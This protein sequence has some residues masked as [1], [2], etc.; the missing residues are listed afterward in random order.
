M[1]SNFE[2]GYFMNKIIITAAVVATTLS[3]CGLYSKYEG[4]TSVDE[5]L[6]GDVAQSVDG[7]TIGDVAWSDLFTDTKLRGYIAQALESN[8][9]LRMAK[10]RVE[11]SEASL[12]SSRLAYLPSV[13][14]APEG[15]ISGLLESGSSSY[16]SYTL[17]IAASWELDL[18]G[19]I[20]NTKLRTKMLAD[21]QQYVEQATR[22]EIVAAVANVYYTIAMLE[23]QLQ[24]AKATEQSWN[25]SYRTSQ[26][27]MDAGMMNQAGLSQIEAGLYSVQI[28]VAKLE[29][30]LTTMHNTMC[31]LLATAPTEIEVG[32]LDETIIPANLMVGVPLQML[33]SRPDVMAAESALAASFYSKNV[34]RSALYP[35]LSLTGALGWSNSF[36]SVV[37]DP[38][39]FIY[40]VVGQ[41]VQ[42]IFNRGLTRAQIKVATADLEIARITFEQKLLDAGIEVNNS[43]RA[44]Q[45][46]SSNAKLYSEQVAAMKLAADQ[47]ALLM[48]NG[49]V[50]YLEVL[51][52]QQSYFNSQLGEVSNRFEELQSLVS[53]YKSLGG[54]RF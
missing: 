48:E 19:R 16:K 47:T 44:L 35:S 40:S 23:E 21:Q 51:T 17:P 37:L 39:K 32:S 34:A 4:T 1:L 18:F 22:T 43:L 14:F 26:A 28:S 2:G 46:A 38:A 36:G 10:L 24:I 11:Q 41:L 49:N 25:E 13:S 53:L 7:A 33:S 45:I 31:S 5:S 15:S 42:P 3:S 20:T 27:M 8:S 30:E 29:D 50:T 54:G 12:V 6:Y 9:D 52:S